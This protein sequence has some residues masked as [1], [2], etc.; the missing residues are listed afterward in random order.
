MNFD[1]M[2]EAWSAQEEK[3]LYGVNEDLLR[4]VLQGEHDKIRRKLR[5]DQ[6]ITYLVGPGMALFAAFWVWVAVVSVAL[7]L[8]RFAVTGAKQ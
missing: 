1:Q 3:P 5:R 4:L 6:W 7:V 2:L 8:G